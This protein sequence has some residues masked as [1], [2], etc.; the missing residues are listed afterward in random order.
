MIRLLAAGLLV[1]VPAGARTIAVAAGA[2]AQE[3]LQTA[4]I[5]ARPGDTVALAAGRFELTEG[6]S[7]DVPD[8][9][10]TG[11][12]SDRTTLS[13]DRQKGEGEGL[14]VTSKNVTL[15]DFAVENARGNGIKA[16][17]ADGIS[18]V[19]LRVVW[20]GGPK[21]TNGAYG[22]YPVSSANV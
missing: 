6:L 15:R 3:R 14:L 1:A 7:L 13:F 20:T 18:F 5:D 19:R 10:V 17:A 16:K 21:E 2:D 9:T 11:A 22:V 12:G 4:L 8:V